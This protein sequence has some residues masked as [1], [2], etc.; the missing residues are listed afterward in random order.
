MA[1]REEKLALV[2]KK[3]A[4]RRN[5]MTSAAI[6]DVSKEIKSTIL[7]QYRWEEL[8]MAAPVAINCMGGCFIAASSPIATATKISTFDYETSN[9]DSQVITNQ[10]SPTSLQ[11]GLVQASNLGRIAFL[12]AE[13]GMG[14]IKN[15]SAAMT[16]KNCSQILNCLNNPE[17]AK[18]YLANYMGLFQKSADKCHSAALMMDLKFAQWLTYLCKFHVSCVQQQSETEAKRLQNE[19]DI[20]AKEIEERTMEKNVAHSKEAADMYKTQ[21]KDAQAQVKKAMESFPSGMEVL[22]GDLASSYVNMIGSGLNAA[23]NLGA[24]Y[25]QSTNPAAALGGAL[26]GAVGAGGQGQAQAPQAAGMA[27]QLVTGLLG[28]LGQGLQNAGQNG[29]PEGL[30]QHLL[31]GL[32][33]TA[34]QT[35]AGVADPALLQ[36][37]SIMIYLNILKGIVNGAD[38][39][40]WEQVTASSNGHSGFSYAVQMLSSVKETFN[41]PQPIGSASSSLISVLNIV[42]QTVTAIRDHAGEDPKLPKTDKRVIKWQDDFNKQYN[43]AVQL[44]ANGGML[45]GTPI[46]A[47]PSYNQVT[48]ETHEQLQKLQGDVQKEGL[49]PQ[50]PQ[51]RGAGQAMMDNARARANAA[52]QSYKEA[53]SRYLESNKRLM[54]TQ[55]AL[56]EVQAQMAKLKNDKITLEEVKEVLMKSIV[57]LVKMKAQVEKLVK[58]FGA[59]A[60]TVELAIETAV[61]PFIET[62]TTAVGGD[63]DNIKGFHLSDFTR[64]CIFQNVLTIRAYFNVF[65]Q[66]ATMWVDLSNDHISPG[67][68]LTENLGQI[69]SS[70][71]TKVKDTISQKANLLQQWAEGA[72]AAVAKKARETQEGIESD[73]KAR[74]KGL[75]E[76]TTLLLPSPEERKAIED[77]KA[78]G[79]TPPASVEPLDLDFDF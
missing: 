23:A 10:T 43:I 30:G 67:I 72:K 70:N 35:I 75:A 46:N 77:A 8:L 40:D 58:F 36:I 78:S 55:I 47:L 49:Q 48:K 76:T 79:V 17:D 73:M 68:T 16:G 65:G 51:Q 24:G 18:L 2:V 6:N 3:E 31:G 7:F 64:D 13:R 25:L 42:Y 22:L 21:V 14:T 61:K 52:N 45:P 29:T 4:D 38:G 41:P 15:Y 56:G 44:Q 26:G 62:V 71:D 54:E 34:G 69:A 1:T 19:I 37:N 20:T 59:L 28:N 63:L 9:L 53:N 60:Q 66:V 32:L 57:L 39:V 33:N 11:A 74:I 27:Q 50:T 5:A 12:Q